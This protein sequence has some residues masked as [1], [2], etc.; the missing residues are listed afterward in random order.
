MT[1]AS[2]SIYQKLFHFC[3]R[4]KHARRTSTRSRP[5]PVVSSQKTVGFSCPCPMCGWFLMYVSQLRLFLLTVSFM[6]HARLTSSSGL[7][8]RTTPHSNKLSIVLRLQPLRKQQRR[9]SPRVQP[10]RRDT[11]EGQEDK[12]CRTSKSIDSS[13]CK[14]RSS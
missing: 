9:V 6:R 7:D 1:S 11:Q 8:S 3:S 2:S 14:L 5:R 4:Q 12:S 10:L 13:S